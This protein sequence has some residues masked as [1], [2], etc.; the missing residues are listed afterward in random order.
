MLPASYLEESEGKMLLLFLG[1][2]TRVFVRGFQEVQVERD[3]S[4][5]STL[6]ASLLGRG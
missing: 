3:S 6:K 4:F 1:I 5:C 2:R